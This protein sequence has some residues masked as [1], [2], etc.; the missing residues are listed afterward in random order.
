LDWALKQ[1]RVQHP[2]RVTFRAY[3]PIHGRAY[4]TEI[5]EIEQIGAFAEIDARV[6]S[7]NRII[8]SITNAQRVALRPDPALLNLEVPIAVSVNGHDL[9]QGKCRQSEEIRL[10]KQSGNWSAEIVSRE[11]R[12]RTAYRTHQIGVAIDPPDWNGTGETTMGNWRADMIRAAAG[13]DLAICTRNYARGIPLKAD[14]PIFLV[15]LINWLRPTEQVLV[16]F[17]ISGAD[18]LEILEQNLVDEPRKQ[19]FFLVNV[20]GC[21]Y[22]FDRNRPT[23]HRITSS[24]IDPQKVYIVGC[25]PHLLTR[26]DTLMLGEE[27]GKFEFKWLGPTLTTAAWKNIV[28]N[29]GR[30][31]SRLDGRLRDETR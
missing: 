7:G 22:S 30:L 29:H 28:E 9:F 6:E 13:T 20:S 17:P 31:T 4:W 27:R 11:P 1:R 14:Q 3:L 19:A 8:T 26:T 2:E 24:D 25:E 5:Q 12:P 18:L 23:G 16:S 10:T 15:D 21:R